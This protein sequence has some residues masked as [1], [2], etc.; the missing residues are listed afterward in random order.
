MVRVLKN[1]CGK[2]TEMIHGFLMVKLKPSSKKNNSPQTSG[3]PRW[4]HLNTFKKRLP[5]PFVLHG[6]PRNKF[7][8]GSSLFFV[9]EKN[10]I[11]FLSCSDV[12]HVLLCRLPYRF[13][14]KF[15]FQSIF[16]PVWLTTFFLFKKREAGVGIPFPKWMR[17][18]LDSIFGCKI[19]HLL[20]NF[21]VRLY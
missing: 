18:I 13:L 7:L 12:I 17:P 9:C 5:F 11:N 10:I 3:F 16:V 15:I 1:S 4:R 21:P 19:T 8:V 20:R 2:K 14:L 6:N